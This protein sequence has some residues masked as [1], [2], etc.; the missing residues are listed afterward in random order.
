MN[1][2]TAHDHREVSDS[3]RQIVLVDKSQRI[4]WT[5]CLELS[6]KFCQ[7]PRCGLSTL[8][9]FP[10]FNIVIAAFC[11]VSHHVGKV[12]SKLNIFD[13]SEAFSFERLSRIHLRRSAGSSRTST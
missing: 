8:K 10:N 7:L 12:A 5:K 1:G 11:V 9:H 3:V 13:I 4:I 2:F 6:G